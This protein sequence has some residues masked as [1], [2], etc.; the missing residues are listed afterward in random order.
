MQKLKTK[1]AIDRNP[2]FVQDRRS[3]VLRPGSDAP[4]VL[5]PDG[6]RPRPDAAT[7][8]VNTNSHTAIYTYILGIKK[9]IIGI[10]C[11]FL[12]RCTH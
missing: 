9:L 8:S 5:L 11:V 6:G 12:P 10:L 1:K 3:A 4:S 7:P 2:S